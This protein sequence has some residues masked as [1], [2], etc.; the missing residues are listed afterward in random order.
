VLLAALCKY[1][2]CIYL[3]SVDVKTTYIWPSYLCVHYTTTGATDDDHYLEP[4]SSSV[5]DLT[6]EEESPVTIMEEIIQFFRDLLQVTGGD[7]AP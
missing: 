7:L 5:S 3:V 2:N 4:I 1:S 6:P